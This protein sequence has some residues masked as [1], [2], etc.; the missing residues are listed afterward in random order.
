VNQQTA[1]RRC[2]QSHQFETAIVETN[3][4]DNTSNVDNIRQHISHDGDKSVNRN[5]Q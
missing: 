2:P 1:E 5:G 3:N 4:V